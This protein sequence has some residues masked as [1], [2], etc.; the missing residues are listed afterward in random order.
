MPSLI[1]PNLDTTK[2]FVSAWDIHALAG[3]LKRSTHFLQE[4]VSRKGLLD[5][6]VG[7]YTGRHDVSLAQLTNH[8]DSQTGMN[9]EAT[10]QKPVNGR[11]FPRLIHD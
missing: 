7:A 3:M 1:Y 8:K 4:F 6:A 10:L 2:D 9:N 5:K 11:G